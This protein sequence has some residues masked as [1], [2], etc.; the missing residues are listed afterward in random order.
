MGNEKFDITRPLSIGIVLALIL[1]AAAHIYGPSGD[2]GDRE[3]PQIDPV[4]EQHF[5]DAML[6]FKV[7]YWP[8][9]F[10]DGRMSDL[11]KGPFFILYNDI[12]FPDM[13]QCEWRLVKEASE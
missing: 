10:Y 1:A 6:E 13:Y 11:C 8:M 2:G 7:L 5:F 12:D 4:V 9:Q 3:P